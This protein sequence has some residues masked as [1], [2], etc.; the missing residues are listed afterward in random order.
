[1]AQIISSSFKEI[2]L[3]KVGNIGL[4]GIYVQYGDKYIS[5]DK[6][7]IVT[8]TQKFGD[9]KVVAA[10]RKIKNVADLK[11][12]YSN[13]CYQDESGVY[14]EKFSKPKLYFNGFIVPSTYESTSLDVTGATDEAKIPYGLK[15]T[16]KVDAKT[17]NQDPNRYLYV[18]VAEGFKFAKLDEIYWYKGTEKKTYIDA[19]KSGESLESLTFFDD[20]NNEIITI[21]TEYEYEF[22]RVVSKEK[23]NLK[24]NT[25]G[26]FLVDED[27]EEIEQSS[28]KI[29]QTYTEQ[30]YTKEQVADETRPGKK[31][32][33]GKIYAK[34][35]VSVIVDESSRN[36]MD[37]FVSLTVKDALNKH[38]VMAKLGDLLDEND[39]LI[40]DLSLFV[41]KRV[42]IKGKD[43]LILISE[44][45]TFEQANL[46]FDTIKTYQEHSGLAD[47]NSCLRLENGDYVNEMS[48]VQPFAYKVAEGDDYDHYLVEQ[49]IAGEK[50]FVIVSP[51]YFAR[52]G[53]S[54]GLN[55]KRV[56]KIKRCS[57]NDASC[58]IIQTTSNEEKIEQCEIIG[59]IK[60]EGKL[61]TKSA[62]SKA[63]ILAKFREDYINNKYKI[64]DVLCDGEF[65]KIQKGSKRYKYTDEVEQIDHAENLTE[66]QAL[67]CK[68]I[69]VKNGKIIGGSNF[70]IKEAIKSDFKKWNKALFRGVPF[71]V[72]AGIFIPVVGPIV[73]AA[74][75]TGM[76][77]AIPGIPIVNAIRGMIKNRT[78]KYT[79][80]VEFNRNKEVVNIEE[81]IA[82]LTESHSMLND[83]QFEDIYSRLMA[84]ITTLSATTKLNILN[85]H[86]GRA[87][88]DSNNVQFADQYVKSYKKI[89]KKLDFYQLRVNQYNAIGKPVPEKTQEEYNKLKWQFENLYNNTV[90]NSYSADSRFDDL[91]FRVTSLKTY[92]KLTTLEDEKLKEFLTEM[93]LEASFDVSRISYDA[94]RGIML[95]GVAVS[96]TEKELEKEFNKDKNR[97]ELWQGVREKILIRCKRERVE[98]NEPIYGNE[99][100]DDHLE[101]VLDEERE[102][103]RVEEDDI[104]P[105]K[106]KGKANKN[107]IITENS[108]VAQLEDR[109]SSTYELVTKALKKGKFKLEDDQV[110]IEIEKFIDKIN[111]AHNNRVSARSLFKKGSIELYIFN[112]A[113]KELNNLITMN[114]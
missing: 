47:E 111:E 14:V 108:I 51:E 12:N 48:S 45:L 43:G 65:R 84:E 36:N 10:S 79:N 81:Q 57:V 92:H 68:N 72:A 103:E 35:Y 88:V 76:T 78:K 113:S 69:E 26:M 15:R 16:L 59:D 25:R 21:Y 20:K 64:N 61:L 58:S 44:P 6:L 114:Y 67:N 54:K 106:K 104:D 18:K 3:G 98:I 42:K 87:K 5:L 11:L 91:Y 82:S 83:K 56:V 112:Y 32:L 95:D 24:N 66:Y 33:V 17:P 77:L 71:A 89:K 38:V 13:L 85:V 107:I 8:K 22:P 109:K 9:D 110:K 80:K 34:N 55:D 41:G 29:A 90:A 105:K 37:L 2:K 27:G 99:S 102:P 50:K 39:A 63:D 31:K 40:T 4:R 96:A 28:Q 23:I 74:Y 53:K 101:D 62:N 100:V 19:I 46:R 75:A 86:N 1:M 93:E 73:A 97:R 94:K 7:E 70:S 60:L 49:T 30:R 52:H